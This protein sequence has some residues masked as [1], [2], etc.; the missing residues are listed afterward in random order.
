M[1]TSWL[2]WVAKVC[3]L[4]GIVGC[5]AAPVSSENAEETAAGTQ[6]AALAAPP[7]GGSWASFTSTPPGGL[8]TCLQLTNGDVM[9]HESST[10]VWHRLRP[11]A[12]GSYKNGSWDNPPI[13]PMPNGNGN[14]CSNCAYAPLYFASAVLKDGRAVVVGGEYISGQ[15][16]ESNIGFIYDPLTNT[17]SN[18]LVEPSGSV[19]DAMS[20]V[21]QDGTFVIFNIFDSNVEVLDQTTGVFTQ[22]NPSGKLDR[23]SE[24][25]PAPLYDGTV[26]AVDSGI[27]A[28]FERY[29]PTTNTWGNSGSMPVNLADTGTGSG[30]ST[31]VGPCALRPDN[32]VACF[33]GNPFGQNAIYNPT[34][35]SWSH[36]AS[37]DFP[38]APGGGHFAMADGPAA[39]LPNGNI[40]VLAS[41]VTTTSPFNSPSHFYELGLADNTLTAVTDT[42]NAGNIPSYV[43]RMIVLPTG[44]VLYDGS[45][46]MLYTA[47][48]APQDAWRPAITS[49]PSTLSPGSSYVVSGRQLNGFS[50]GASYGDDAQSA[51]NYPL[52]RITNQATG[53]V[54]YARTFNP[55]RMGVVPVGS[56]TVVST[57]F[58]VPSN[59]ETGAAT[60]QVVTNGIA[61]AGVAVTVS[62]TT[63]TALPRTGWV[64]SASNTNGADAPGNAL[65][66]NT[67]TRWSDGIA[68]SNATTHTFTVD[69]LAP[70]SFSQIKLDSNGDY[71]RNYQVFVSNDGS[72]WGSA[73]AS[74][75]SSSQS[76]TITFTAVTARYIQVRQ[77]V[78][79]GVGSW[80][81][82]YEF[83]VYGSGTGG[84]GSALPRTGWMLSASA[85][86]AGDSLAGAIDGN[87]ATRWSSGAPQSNATTQTLTVDMLSAQ[88]FDKLT[89]LSNGDYARNYQVFASNNTSSW[90]TAIATGTGTTGT[91][92]IMFAAQNARYLQIRQTTAAGVGSWWSVYELNVYSPA[93]APTALPRS[94]WTATGSSTAESPLNALDGVASTR[95]SSGAAQVNGQF[96]QVDMQSAKA[97]RQLTLDSTASAGDY[98]RG[99]Q[100]FVS[101]DGVSWGSA[102]ASGTPT[103]SV[104]TITFAPQSARYIKVV[105][106]GT[107]T[108]NWW[109]IHEFNVYN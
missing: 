80:W 18:Q 101:N 32:Q 102:I 35:N 95:W 36:T 66:G 22:R 92:T 11:D 76:T 50:E 42:P 84:G 46:T 52:V 15:Q 88:A 61:S 48:G 94:G 72:N 34:T 103:S 62:S 85:T 71:A 104:V 45:D 63:L 37:M 57:N 82:I 9:C 8:G 38:A 67:A 14:G 24:E 70:Q 75:S 17:W 26:L 99:Y 74:G 93:A 43:G 59:V 7:V 78:A 33:S 19:G 44:E 41:P 83:N 49:V 96:Y 5:S 29:N 69:M 10:N 73:I 1:R 86:A 90:G 79:A 91:T 106:T 39:S 13:A 30:F 2:V 40:L 53:H 3:A 6:A 54:F 55:S 68:Q 100:V 109:S 89:L 51:T 65:D 16:V 77:S 97:F 107:V 87:T 58:A 47:S 20:L 105:Q 21:L 25:N 81:S 31:E 64:A 27:A 23:N 60:L 56:T 4:A 28:S 12:F 98:P 108:P